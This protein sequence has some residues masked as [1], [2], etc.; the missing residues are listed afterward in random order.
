MTS[1]T[2]YT[3]PFMCSIYLLS[4]TILSLSIRELSRALVCPLTSAAV[5]RPRAS[6]IDVKKRFYVFLKFWSRFLL[7]LTFLFSE[8]FLFLK[9]RWQGSE[10]QAG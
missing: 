6:S 10:R 7:F 9:K 1:V 4:L 5:M 3:P 2:G 8:R